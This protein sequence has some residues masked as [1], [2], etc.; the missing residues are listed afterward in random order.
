MYQTMPHLSCFI[1]ELFCV[2]RKVDEKSPI[3]QDKLY[4]FIDD[5]ICG[6]NCRPPKTFKS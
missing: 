5:K 2:N 3:Y 4:K 6:G 1:A